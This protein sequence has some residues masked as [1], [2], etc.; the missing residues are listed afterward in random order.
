M[1]VTGK[2]TQAHRPPQTQDQAGGSYFTGQLGR[3]APP[4]S[5]WLWQSHLLRRSEVCFALPVPELLQ[6][7]PEPPA[8]SGFLKAM[9]MWK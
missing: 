2:R 8:T 7:S 6:Q 4:P 1:A 9:K 3:A 5:E